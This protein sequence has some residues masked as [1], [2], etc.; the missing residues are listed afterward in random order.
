MT[1]AVTAAKRAGIELEVLEYD[2]SSTAPLPRADASI[3][4]PV[5]RLPENEGVAITRVCRAST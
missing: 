3:A 2:A 1:P 5:R 4:S